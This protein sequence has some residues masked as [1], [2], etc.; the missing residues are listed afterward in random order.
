MILE[1]LHGLH[2][3]IKFLFGEKELDLLPLFKTSTTYILAQV[4]HYFQRL[5]EFLQ[6]NTGQIASKINIKILKNGLS[7]IMITICRLKEN[8]IRAFGIFKE[9]NHPLEE[10]VLLT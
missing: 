2:L 6:S 8:Y 3:N 5:K 7:E 10:S 1:F 4:E 9:A